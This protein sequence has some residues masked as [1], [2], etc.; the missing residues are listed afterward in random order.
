[1]VSLSLSHKNVPRQSAHMVLDP[2]GGFI[3]NGLVRNVKVTVANI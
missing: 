1:M 3:I 2:D